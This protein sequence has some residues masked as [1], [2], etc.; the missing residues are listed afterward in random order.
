MVRAEPLTK[1]API[2]KDRPSTEEGE[3]A[4]RSHRLRTVCGV[5]AAGLVLF[6]LH[7][8]TAAATKRSYVYRVPGGGRLIVPRTSI[9]D[10]ARVVI[11]RIRAPRFGANRHALG[12]AVSLRMRDG[13]LVGP[14]TLRLPY[15][16]RIDTHG[17][18]L[19]LSVQLAYFDVRA[20]QWHVVPARVNA[21]RK[22][23]SA[24]ITHFSWWNPFSWDWGSIALRL[25]QRVGELRGART[26][27]AK[28]VSGVPVPDWARTLTHNDA[29]IQLRTCAEGQDG[30]V[31][32]QIVNNRPYG[33]TLRYGAPV[34]WGWHQTPADSA[35]AV[36]SMMMDKLVTANELYVPPLSAAS[37]GV[38]QGAW[39][40]AEFQAGPTQQTTFADVMSFITDKIDVRLVRPEFVGDLASTCSAQ[41]KPTLSG[42]PTAKSDAIGWIEATAKCVLRT[43]PKAVAAGHLDNMTAQQLK[44]VSSALSG[45]ATGAMIGARIGKIA[46]WWIGMR[47]DMQANSTFSISRVSGSGDGGTGGEGGAGNGGSGGSGPSGGGGGSGGT[48]P[49]AGGGRQETVGGVTHTWTNYTNAGGYEGPQIPAY[50]TVTVACKLQGFRVADG[51]TWWYR[52][53][54]PP[55]TG[56]YH[57]SADAFYNNGQT[58]GSLHGTPFVDPAVPNC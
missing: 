14:V 6:G 49:P 22:T 19:D 20:G 39:N 57:A 54:S 46:D 53:A 27:P 7:A 2:G 56:T 31:V 51:N 9:T 55:W 35:G 43:L 48:G 24:Q 33:V 52:I 25:D 17:M 28:C 13:R 30:K 32:V 47:S 10:G 41:L 34:A 58:S 8:S 12:R 18:P 40:Y 29:D 38:P 5:V 45:L 21:R 36:G 15:R 50:T 23:I 26:A 16:G 1:D 44:H 11:R 42:F 3:A 4:V 37:V